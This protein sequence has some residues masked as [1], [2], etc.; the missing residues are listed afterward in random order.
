MAPET[1]WRE[2]DFMLETEA[3][4]VS[5]GRD[6]RDPLTCLRHL[7]GGKVAPLRPLLLRPQ[8]LEHQDVV[9]GRRQAFAP[10]S[11]PPPTASS[12]RSRT[13]LA[14]IAE[15]QD[16]TAEPFEARPPSSARRS[17]PLATIRQP[18]FLLA[19]GRSPG[20]REPAPFTFLRNSFEL[21]NR[22]PETRR[23]TLEHPTDRMSVRAMKRA[24]L[25]AEH[26]RITAQLEAVEAK[27]A[28]AGFAPFRSA[29][30][31]ESIS[32]ARAVA[33]GALDPPQ[34]LGS[35]TARPST[36]LSMASVSSAST[37]WYNMHHG[38]QMA[39]APTGQHKE[40]TATP[41]PPPVSFF[42]KPGDWAL[43]F[44]KTK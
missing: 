3:T 11:I 28:R 20:S 22:V 9:R 38:K 27:R 10:R 1:I 7:K 32:L 26:A 16:A 13:L 14:D 42:P 44:Q 31:L 17:T 37:Y 35:T 33:S 12:T 5:A 41:P 19:D 4:H 40:W 43:S 18:T 2:Y 36:A 24:A 8:D 39:L 25:K 30:G 29:R 6:T 15:Q 21:E 34:A 23:H